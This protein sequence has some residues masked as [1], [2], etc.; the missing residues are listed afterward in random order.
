[1]TPGQCSVC[2]TFQAPQGRCEAASPGRQR[3]WAGPPPSCL[4]APWPLLTVGTQ[5]VLAGG[6]LSSAICHSALPAH[7]PLFCLG[8][9]AGCSCLA[10]PEWQRVGRKVLGVGFQ[11]GCGGSVL[12]ELSLV[13]APRPPQPSY[14]RLLLPITRGAPAAQRG[15]ACFQ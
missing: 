5:L 8:G 14:R 1:M 4:R 15:E 2:R 12:L 13:F 9:C 7:H 11:R 6:P 10:G 3:S